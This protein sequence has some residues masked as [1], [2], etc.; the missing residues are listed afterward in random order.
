MFLFRSRFTLP[1]NKKFL[2]CFVAEP[3][4]SILNLAEVILAEEA[5][6]VEVGA[7]VELGSGYGD[8]TSPP[9]LG[10]IALSGSAFFK[11]S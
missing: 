7:P 5:E 6:Y 11:G 4:V 1:I 2:V 10:L 9:S 8:T 3:S